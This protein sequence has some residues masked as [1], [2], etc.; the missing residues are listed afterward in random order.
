[1]L[2]IN[3]F[4]ADRQ[5]TRAV[6]FRA[7]QRHRRA[8]PLEGIEQIIV[9]VA[10]RHPEYHALLENPDAHEDRDYPPELGAA[11]PFMH[12]GLHVA[13][14]EQLSTDRPPGVR[15]CYLSLLKKSGDEHVA[16][17]CV[18]ECLGEALWRAG[19]ERA[20][21]NDAE[22]LECLRLRAQDRS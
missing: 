6:F 13:I 16:Q 18:L 2:S 9:A 4:A 17:H 11:N 5:Q 10:L 14:E 19:R 8:E 3:V 15:D 20:P 1:L 22:Y 7:W 21:P 12:L